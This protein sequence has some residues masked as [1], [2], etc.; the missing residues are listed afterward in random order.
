MTAAELSVT[1]VMTYGLEDVS[2]IWPSCSAGRKGWGDLHGPVCN[3]RAELYL[4]QQFS[5]PAGWR[6]IPLIP[7]KPLGHPRLQLH[8]QQRGPIWR[9]SLRAE[10]S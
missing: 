7:P 2:R 4:Q 3:Q 9:R 1:A 5:N 8:K 10:D 6:L